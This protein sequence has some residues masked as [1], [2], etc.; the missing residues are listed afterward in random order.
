MGSAALVSVT[1][2]LCVGASEHPVPELNLTSQGWLRS[3]CHWTLSPLSIEHISCFPLTGSSSV[4]HT[5]GHDVNELWASSPLLSHTGHFFSFPFNHCSS[6]ARLEGE[7]QQS[8]VFVLFSECLQRA[9]SDVKLMMLL[10][11]VG[12]PQVTLDL[13]LSHV[14][15]AGWERSSVF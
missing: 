5:V 7:R 8:C 14:Q 11:I 13:G 3:V 15:E 6:R 2:R 4:C 9:T 1:D 10:W 12:G